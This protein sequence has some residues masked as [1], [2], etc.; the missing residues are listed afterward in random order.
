MAEPQVWEVPQSPMQ[1]DPLSTNS[2]CTKEWVRPALKLGIYR[3]STPIQMWRAAD[4]LPEGMSPASP[5]T[6]LTSLESRLK[7]VQSQSIKEKHREGVRKR[8]FAPIRELVFDDESPGMQCEPLFSPGLSSQS[9]IEGDSSRY[10]QDFEELGL[11]SSGHYGEV[12]R[13]RHR[14]DRQ[15]Y[16]VKR[17]DLTKGQDTSLS[18]ALALAAASFYCDSKHIL[19]YRNMW[20]ERERLYI[21]TELCQGSLRDWAQSELSEEEVLLALRDV[22]KGLRELHAMGVVHLDVKPDNILYSFSQRFKLGDLGLARLIDTLKGNREIPEGDSRYL[23]PELLSDPRPNLQKCDIFALGASIYE[24]MNN[25]NLPSTGESW[26]A[27]RQGELS[28]KPE[29]SPLLVEVVTRMLS[30]DPERRPT[31]DEIVRMD[32]S[33][34]SPRR[35]LSFS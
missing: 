34:N 4:K 28:F 14:L 22:A 24:V 33:E 23:A 5:H 9:S 10:T 8:R 21:S 25:A 6:P 13:C 7:L 1:V 16:A 27:L 15:L 35:K 2:P 11:L 12:Y 17:I 26:H 29:W 18:E 20:V 3:D 32:L 31:A 30:A 19:R